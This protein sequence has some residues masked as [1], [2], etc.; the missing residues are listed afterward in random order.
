M[1]NLTNGSKLQF[2]CNTQFAAFA[3]NYLRFLYEYCPMMSIF[4]KTCSNLRANKRV[5]F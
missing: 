5:L 4:I 3:N 2:Y 1:L